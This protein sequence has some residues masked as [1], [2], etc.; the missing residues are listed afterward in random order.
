MILLV[1]RIRLYYKRPY[2][3]KLIWVRT[4]KGEQMKRKKGFTLIELLVVIS[5]IAL[6]LSILMPALSKVKAQAKQVVCSSNLKQWGLIF[7]TYLNDHYDKFS[8]G[9]H[10]PDGSYND[11]Q[12]G[13]WTRSMA[14]YY[15]DSYDLFLCP[16]AAKPGVN[17]AGNPVGGIAVAKAAWGLLKYD[18]GKNWFIDGMLGSYGLNFYA[19]DAPIIQPPIWEYDTM[20][21]WRTNNVNGANNI[22]LY[23][24]SVWVSVG[25]VTDIDSPP[26]FEGDL[27]ASWPTND[28]KNIC[29]NRHIGAINMLFMDFSAREVGLKQL[30]GLKWHKTFDTNNQY[31]Q[32][33][34]PWPKWMAKY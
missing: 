9:T 20:N 2:F 27:P 4:G 14:G 8:S 11:L 19:Y 16:E 1:N 10:M 29:I 32:Q 7:G 22:P 24:D 26:L 21:N 13:N 28:M 30:W 31:R 17:S 34:A 5:I 18:P 12:P 6:L 33:G 23:F 25:P 3:R 15:P